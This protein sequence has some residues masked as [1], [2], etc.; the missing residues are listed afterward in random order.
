MLKDPQDKKQNWPLDLDQT[1]IWKASNYKSLNDWF[2]AFRQIFVLD[3]QPLFFKT[4][5]VQW[6]IKEETCPLPKQK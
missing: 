4:P 6:E 5:I 2:K 1:K 3:V